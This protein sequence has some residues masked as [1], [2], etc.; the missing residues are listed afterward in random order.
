MALGKSVNGRELF[1]GGIR[2]EI[3]VQSVPDTDKPI[4]VRTLPPQAK[5]SLSLR[6]SIYENSSCAQEA[7]KWLFKQRPKV[8]NLYSR[9]DQSAP[10]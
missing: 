8:R 1:F 10:I 3:N 4:E 5:S 9:E 2:R 7:A 6:H